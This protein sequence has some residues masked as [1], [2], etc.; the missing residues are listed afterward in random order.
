VDDVTPQPDLAAEPPTV[1]RLAARVVVIDRAGR[2][3]LFRG[4]DPHR[5][6]AGTWWFTPG[7]G[8]EEGESLAVAARREVFEE[9]G[10]ELKDVGDPVL[11]RVVRFGFEGVVYDQVEHFFVACV[12][13]LDVGKV[14]VSGWT[15]VERRSVV[16]QRWWT[17]AQ[18]RATDETFY[19][20]ELP[21]LLDTTSWS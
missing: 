20:V 15:D 17:V 12:D 10:I 14:D 16:E 2:T 9:T 1:A 18:L 5:P 3:L 8:V 19:P 4:G 11:R 21:E 6:E 13:V 7:G